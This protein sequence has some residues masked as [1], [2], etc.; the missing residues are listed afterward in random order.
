MTYQFKFAAI[1]AA[2]VLTGSFSLALAGC[3]SSGSVD[4]PAPVT[5]TVIF[6][7]DGAST[8][9]NPA[10]IPVTSPATTVESLPAAPAKTGYDFGGWWIEKNGGGSAFTATTAVTADMTVYAKWTVV[11]VVAVTPSNTPSES[12]E[13]QP[14]VTPP[15]TPPVTPPVSPPVTPPVAPA[16]CLIKFNANGG[17]GT[18]D[19]QSMTVSSPQALSAN[20]FTRDGYHFIGWALSGTGSIAYADGATP[21]ISEGTLV[22]HAKWEYFQ[23]PASS[24][25]YTVTDGK[26]T[27][28]SF[29]ST[30]QN[31]VIPP[32]I[33]GYPVVSFG[34]GTTSIFKENVNIRSVTIPNTVTAISAYAFYC[35]SCLTT[36]NMPDSITSIGDYAFQ[37]CYNLTSATIPA[38][39]TE[40]GKW[41]FFACKKLPAIVIPSSV[42]TI[43]EFAFASCL[44][45]TVLEI[46]NS[47]TSIGANAFWACTKLTSVTIPNSIT[48][49]STGMFYGC[50][51][52]TSVSIPNS[53]ITIADSTF[54]YC[55]NLE[56][57][58]IPNSVTAINNNAF[59]GCSKITTFTI[60]ASVTSLGNVVFSDTGLTT[61]T[62]MATT[63]PRLFPGSGSFPATL[64][65]IKVPVSVGNTVLADYK[66]AMGWKEFVGIISA[67]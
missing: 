17:S 48:T 54:A 30:S 45:A 24:F 20:V 63:P 26:A 52:L 65:A 58:A 28:T 37:A 40:I 44:N 16:I 8:A 56:T 34:D 9:P 32:T 3:D 25:T 55:S 62:V 11:A 36:V 18:M 21:T 12:P 57:I 35:C 15:I 5:F 23:E 59:T 29:T 7:G 39:V 64:I 33:G 13:T 31:V 22:L 42:L 6:D 50:T 51:A 47:V 27:L 2:V 66:I 46:P 38:S 14:V 43:G 4:D 1:V 19:D 10:T 41:S 60:P 49:I 67:E 61:L 53:V